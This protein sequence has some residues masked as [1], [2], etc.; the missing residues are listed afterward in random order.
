MPSIILRGL[1]KAFRGFVAI[2]HL[3]LEI[4]D[5]EYMVLL[6][7]TGAGK[8]TLLRMIAGLTKPDEGD[9]LIGGKDVTKMLP[10]SRGLTYMSQTYSLFPQLP[11]WDNVRFSPD[12]KGLPSE[13]TDM[14][15]REMLLLVGLLDRREAFPSELSGGMQ[16]RTALARALAASTNVLLLDEPLRALDA[17]LRIALRLSIKKLC[18]DLGITALHVTHDQEEALLVADRVAILRHGRIEQIG[19]SQQVYND[20]ISPFIAQ[21]LGEANFFLGEV[22]E[23]SCENTKLHSGNRHWIARTSSLHPGQDACVAAKSE[24]VRIVKNGDE[25]PNKFDA[26]VT[27]KL[28]LGRFIGLE[29]RSE[30]TNLPVRIRLGAENGK[31]IEEGTRLTLSIEPRD[32]MVFV[33]PPSGLERELEVE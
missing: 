15:A 20:P 13:D 11:V 3:D 8:T 12:V 24:K 6:G 14:L 17:R 9:V 31:G 21:F 25:A 2:D 1:T 28:F 22:D 10:E 19:L 4:K 32:L 16:Q 33:I 27:R 7:P 18:R 30:E 23:V 5:G 29:M 26:V